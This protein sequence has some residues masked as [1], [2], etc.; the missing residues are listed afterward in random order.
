MV[1]KAFKGF[2]IGGLKG[3]GF[4]RARFGVYVWYSWFLCNM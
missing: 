3:L 1:G 2:R 4:E